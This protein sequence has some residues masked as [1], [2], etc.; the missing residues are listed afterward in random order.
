MF[1]QSKYRISWVAVLFTLLLA[2]YKVPLEFGSDTLSNDPNIRMIDTLTVEVSTFQLDS[3]VTRNT[4]VFI[5]GRQQDPAFGIVEAK[6]YFEITA[7]ANDLANCTNCLFDSLEFRTK[8]TGTFTG[9]STV[10]F[11]FS[12]HQ[13]TQVMDEDL[14]SVGY[15]ISNAPFA[16]IPLIAKTLSVRPSANTEV[17]LKLPTVFGQSLFN[18]LKR[19]SDTIINATNFLKYS[20]GFCLQG[21]PSNNAIYHMLPYDSGKSVIRLYYRTN[22]AIPASKYVDFKLGNSQHQFNGFTYDK[23]GTV[24]SSFARKKRQTIS[25]ALLGN[26]GYLHN[27]SGLFPKITFTN[28]WSV[29]ELHPYVKVIKAEIEIRPAA[30]SYGKTTFYNLPSPLN[31]YPVDADDNI[32]DSAINGELIIDDLYGKDTRYTF[33]VTYFVN[34]VLYLGRASNRSMLLKPASATDPH[35]LIINDRTG[36]NPIKL[37]LYIL[38]L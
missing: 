26:K 14:A 11:T 8:F 25:S 35:R 2:C 31:L 4:N 32:V 28:L 33:D 17:K 19:N 29:K 27:N 24:T 22:G 23:S 21:N 7:P 3:F 18:L 1:I 12:L 15:N 37:K 38:G 10:P 16:S 34:S 9:D 6:A 13:L 20:R 5:L 36:S 30:G